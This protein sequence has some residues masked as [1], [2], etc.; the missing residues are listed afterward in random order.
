MNMSSASAHRSTFATGAPSA[1]ENAPSFAGFRNATTTWP[2][3]SFKAMG[4]LVPPRRPVRHFLARGEIDDDDCLVGRIVDENPI[5]TS[6]ELEALGMRVELDIGDFVAAGWID[7]RQCTMAVC[8]IHAIAHCIHANVVGIGA[9]R[10]PRNLPI[11][12]PGKSRPFRRPRWRR[13]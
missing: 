2:A 3:L 10:D 11:V 5:C 12:I 4:K 13:T 6:I 8:H 9:Q 1:M 7:D